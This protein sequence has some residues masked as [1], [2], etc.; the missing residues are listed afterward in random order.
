[1]KKIGIVAAI[2]IGIF[3]VFAII[4]ALSNSSKAPS[5]GPS[6]PYGTE[7]RLFYAD[8]PQVGV[9][10]GRTESDLYECLDVAKKGDELSLSQMISGG[11]L[12]MVSANSRI[13]VLGKGSYGNAWEVKLM[14]GTKAWVAPL[15]IH[16]Q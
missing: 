16:P 8:K 2:V 14:D 4:G 6:F 13:T 1:M 5:S 9:L 3:V 7:A 11:R 15:T 10:V 12:R